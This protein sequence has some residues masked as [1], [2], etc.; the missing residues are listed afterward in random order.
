MWIH[1]AQ[2]RNY[3]SIDNIIDS[4]LEDYL[5]HQFI[6]LLLNLYQI[7]YGFIPIV[8]EFFHHLVIGWWSG[9]R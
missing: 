4:L 6:R 2:S 8:D 3:G 7:L 1:H 9:G 5:F